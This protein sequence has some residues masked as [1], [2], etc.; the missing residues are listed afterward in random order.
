MGP[1]SLGWYK[2]RGL[3]QGGEVTTY[4]SGGRIDLRDDSKEGYGGWDEYSVAPMH[5]EDWNALS[6]WLENLKTI[7]Q[8]DY[9]KLISTFES[10]VLGREIRWW[11]E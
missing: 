9:D 10:E 11:K 8:W 5:G 3:I 1:I 2:D 6:D 7:K 4:Y